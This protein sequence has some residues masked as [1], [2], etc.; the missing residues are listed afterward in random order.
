DISAFSRENTGAYASAVSNDLNTVRT[1]YLE[2]LPYLA[3]LVLNF[4]GT[5]VL[6]LIY[7]VRLALIAFGVSLLPILLSSFRVN[8]V[9]ECE[10]KLAEANGGFLSAFTEMLTGFR[11]VKS[12]RAEQSVGARLLK[13]NRKASDTFADREH[14]EI[15]VAY[16]ASLSGHIA[17]IAFFFISLLLSKNDPAVT[18]GV[19]IAFTQLM[20]NIVQLAVTVPEL[21]ANVKAADKL[22]ERHDGMLALSQ[23]EGEDRAVS[24]GEK[25]EADNVSVSYGEGQE[26]LRNLSLSLP[27]GG[28]YAILGESGSGKTTL[29]NLLSGAKRDYTGSVRYDG[30]EIRNVSGERLF[31]LIS[32]IHQETFLFDATIEENI[33]LFRPVDR[34]VLEDAMKKAGL[35]DLVKEKGLDYA[36]GENGANLSGGEKQRVGIARSILLGS[37]VLLLDEATSALDIRTGSQLI[38]TIQQM[39]GKTR[40]AVTH[41]VYPELMDNFDRIIVLK[42]GQIAGEGIYS[43]LLQT[44]PAL[45]KLVNKG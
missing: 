18:V 44:C 33:T 6:M 1:C 37:G 15:S 10:E 3:E 12:M 42:D 45:Q 26:V 34:A 22:M 20:S 8:Q 5:V 17:R 13:V 39:E 14:T 24:C 7:D 40:I 35:E 28:C 9:A 38:R 41:D 23:A 31:E 30:Q 21:L 25:V 2:S 4:A 32:V 11:A 36:C 43:E 27:A 16:I 19:I 29:L